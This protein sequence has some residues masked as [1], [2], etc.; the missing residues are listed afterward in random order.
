MQLFL[1][2]GLKITALKNNLW[3]LNFVLEWE[4]KFRWTRN[5]DISQTIIT[6]AQEVFFRIKFCSILNFLY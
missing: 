4:I 2:D 3:N 6:Q 5:N 1:V